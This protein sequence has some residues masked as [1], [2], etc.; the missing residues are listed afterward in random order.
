MTVPE[1][2]SIVPPFHTSVPLLIT[3]D[4]RIYLAPVVTRFRVAFAA[5][6]NRPFNVRFVT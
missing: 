1:S 2:H 6:V 4:E 5:T 3:V